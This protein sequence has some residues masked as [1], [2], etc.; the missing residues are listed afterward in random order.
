VNWYAIVHWLHLTLA[1]VWIGGAVSNDLLHRR[2][3]TT[4]DPAV[5]AAL[6][7]FG[8]VVTRKLELHGAILMPILGF[9]MLA[10][11]SGPGFAIFR[12][13][14]WFHLKL[15]AALV[16]IAVSLVAVG[17]QHAIAAAA[18][19]GGSELERRLRSY[20]RLRVVGLL[21]IAII[22][23]SVIPGLMRHSL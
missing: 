14:A 8:A 13:G 23:Y 5:R 11:P 18:E 15:S 3:K 20:F 22:L 2:L 12:S 10:L 17:K 9:L 21:A 1:A 19:A 16:L 6:A 4:A 7:Q